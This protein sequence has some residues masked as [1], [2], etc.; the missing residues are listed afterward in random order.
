MCL[1]RSR[2][3]ICKTCNIITIKKLRNKWLQ[4]LLEQI[5]IIL[6]LFE[7]S[8]KQKWVLSFS[9]WSGLIGNVVSQN[10]IMRINYLQYLIIL[11]TNIHLH[12][13]IVLLMRSDSQIY[14]ESPWTW[15]LF[16]ILLLFNYIRELVRWITLLLCDFLNSY[17][18]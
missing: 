1:A 17:F 7:N 16:K 2:L 18:Y 5:K 4:N 9:I 15:W 8:I 12:I 13:L 6:A 11:A 14:T 10:P 3:A